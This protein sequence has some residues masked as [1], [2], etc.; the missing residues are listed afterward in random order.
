MID[1]A[2][3]WSEIVHYSNKQSV[4]IEN[5]V[6]KVWLCRYP[7]PAII[8]YDQGNEFLGHTFKNDQIEN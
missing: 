5:L 7:H 2:T 3:G 6:E 1:P 4:T 8:T